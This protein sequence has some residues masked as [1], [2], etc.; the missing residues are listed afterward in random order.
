MI[1][2]TSITIFKHPSDHQEVVAKFNMNK[3]CTH[4]LVEVRNNFPETML[5]SY[6]GNW[7]EQCGQ[8]TELLQWE[9][10]FN[11]LSRPPTTWKKILLITQQ[12]IHSYAIFQ[13]AIICKAVALKSSMTASHAWLFQ[14]EKYVK[15]PVYIV[16]G[17]QLL[18]AVSAPAN[19]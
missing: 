12:A 19:N 5:P 18:H 6:R 4:G 17:Y 15:W 14:M 7:L 1:C 9:I 16:H 10:I 2:C 3:F 8:D 11:F 13:H